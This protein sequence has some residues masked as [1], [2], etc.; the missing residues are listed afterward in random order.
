[1]SKRAEPHYVYGV[2][3][4]AERDALSVAGVEGSAVGTVEHDGLAALTS[5]LQGESL[6]AAREIRAHL[7]VLQE[8]SE[9]ATILPVRFGTVL[10]NEGAVRERL[11][12]PNAGRLVD[13]LERLSGCIQ[14]TV[15]GTYDEQRLLEDVV[16]GSPLLTALTQRIRGLPEAAGYYDRI[17]LGEAIAA[18]V[19]ACRE[20]DAAHA[21]SLLEPAA[22]ASRREDLT[23]PYEAFNLSFLVRRTSEQH[24][25]RCVQNVYEKLG[26]RMEVRY[27]GPLPPYSFAEGELE[28]A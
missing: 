4:L 26:E 17:R 28:A 23:A 14:M 18:A 8:A 19:D 15:K 9:A 16:R 7:R 22:L 11:L 3:A 27:V 6:R 2:M 24:F 12:E 13:M 25:S 21:S 1:M 10:E 20:A 5:P